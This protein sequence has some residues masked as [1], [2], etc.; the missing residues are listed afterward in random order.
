MQNTPSKRYQ[1]LQPEERMTPVSYTHL[2]VY[3]RQEYIDG[4]AGN[5]T[6]IGGLGN[7]IYSVDNINDVVIEI[8][9]EGTDLVLASIN[10]TLGEDVENLTLIGTNAIN[11]TGNKMNNVCLLYTSRCV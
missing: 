3:K 9:N 5:D 2:D 4:G 6:M 1:Q 11:G 7:D 8:A 10:Y